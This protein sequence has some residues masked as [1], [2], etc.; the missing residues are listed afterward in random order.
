MPSIVSFGYNQS[1]LGSILTLDSFEKQ[2]HEIDVTTAT[3]TD[4][5]QRSTVQGM[6][7]ALYPVGG[8]FGALPASV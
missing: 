6:I 8:L 1:L 4:K 2:F 3:I 5:A 7:V